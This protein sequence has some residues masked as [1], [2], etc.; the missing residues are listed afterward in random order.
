METVVII[1]MLAVILVFALKL[2]CHG[3]LGASLLSLSVA[4]V[5]WFSRDYALSQSKTMI[6]DWLANPELMLDLA[7][8]LTLDV[9]LMIAFTFMPARP[10]KDVLTADCTPTWQHH[11]NS[12]VRA[13]VDWF[14]GL[15]IYPV[16][17]AILVETFFSLPG[18]DFTIVTLTVSLAFLIVMPLLAMLFKYLLPQHEARAELIFLMALLIA[19]LGV[20]ATV[21]GRTAAA[22]TATVEWLPLVSVIAL[23]AAGSVAGLII[24]RYRKSTKS[25]CRL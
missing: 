2:S 21:N 7:V 6:A 23:F 24:Y 19:A 13:I 4:L 10:R 9:A 5:V 18:A 3:L 17:V 16:A 22:G 1:I 8:V 12:A 14:P 11:L 25:A 20:V 15:L